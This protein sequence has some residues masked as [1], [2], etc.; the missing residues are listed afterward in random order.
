M[1]RGV[2][3]SLLFLLLLAGPAPADAQPKKIPRIGYL[4][5]VS[6]AADAPRL[7]AFRQGLRDLGYVEGQ[8]IVIDYRHE[9]REFDRLADLAAELVRLDIDVLVAVT[10]NAAQAAK[11]G[12]DDDPDRLHG[13][14]RSDRR[15]TG[16]EPRP[17]RRQQH[18]HHQHGRD[19]DRQ[20]PR[21]SE[22]DRSQDLARRG[23][24]GPQGAGL[25][26]AVGTKASCLRGSSGCSSIRWR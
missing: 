16:R 15:R 1:V 12:D 18:R 8:T 17:P 13:R 3:A 21:V 11:K 19:P 25:D 24:V 6:A 20:A 10:T 9:D 22:G 14:D 26:T 7:Q 5:A 23:A 2:L 4:A